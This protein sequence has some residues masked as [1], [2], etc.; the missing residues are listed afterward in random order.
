MRNALLATALCLSVL[1]VPV[2]AHEF[3][4]RVRERPIGND[5]H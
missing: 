2:A 1:S 5:L 4:Q 3:A